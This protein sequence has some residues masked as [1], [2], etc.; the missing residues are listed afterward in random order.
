MNGKTNRGNAKAFRLENIDK[1]YLVIGQDKQT[2]L[3]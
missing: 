1:T 2:S 3:F